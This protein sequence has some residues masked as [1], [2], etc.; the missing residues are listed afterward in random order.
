[1]KCI[2]LWQPW[3]SAIPLLLKQIETRG[4]GT[5]VRGRIG[6]HAAKH[7]A[8]PEQR[9]TAGRR[10]AG[11]PLPDPLPLG[12]VVATA[13]LYDCRRTEDLTAAGISDLEQMYGDYT[14]GRFGWMLS[15]IVAI[16]EPITVPGRQ[17]WFDVPDE[18]FPPAACA[19]P[20]VS[21]S[22]PAAWPFPVSA[23]VE[24]TC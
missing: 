11:D 2:S 20:T 22:K 9:F 21:M 15:E 8:G 12:A 7:W 23:H 18:Y 10:R 5:S 13:V 4:R 19:A 14:P 16:Q 3:A 24:R 6:I 1:M 17:G